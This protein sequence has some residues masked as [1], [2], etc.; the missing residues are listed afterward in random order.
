[1][2]QSIRDKHNLNKINLGD[3]ASFKYGNFQNQPQVQSL[4]LLYA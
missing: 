4:S 1:M 3:Q 2:N